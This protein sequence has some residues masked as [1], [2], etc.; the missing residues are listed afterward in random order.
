MFGEN[1][2]EQLPEAGRGRR[3]D[4]CRHRGAAGARAATLAR[5]ID[6][7]F[8]DAGVTRAGAID[9]GGGEGH[10]FPTLFDHND[11]MPPIEP[12]RDLVR[13]SRLGLEGADAVGNAF[14]VNH[15]DGMCVCRGRGPCRKLHARV[16][17]R[18]YQ[19]RERW[20]MRTTESITGTS[21]STPTTVASAAPD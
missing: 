16:C 3:L 21:M 19:P 6:R 20:T 17:P 8:R 7:E 5:D 2:R 4:Q 15:R 14:V 10:D 12:C 9:G 11:R 1:A 13:A 18:S